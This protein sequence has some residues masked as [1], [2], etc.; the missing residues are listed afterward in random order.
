MQKE[1]RQEVQKKKRSQ[2]NQACDK[3]KEYVKKITY[4]RKI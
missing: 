4:L 1:K 3:Y 2:K